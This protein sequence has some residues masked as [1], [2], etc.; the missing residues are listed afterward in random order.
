MLGKLCYIYKKYSVTPSPGPSEFLRVFGV[1]MNISKSYSRT[2]LT[3]NNEYERV[4]IKRLSIL[5][6]TYNNIKMIIPYQQY[7]HSSGQFLSLVT[8]DGL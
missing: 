4:E 3:C 7:F 8:K 5:S 2:L 6:T 1:F